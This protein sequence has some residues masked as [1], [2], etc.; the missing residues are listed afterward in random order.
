MPTVRKRLSGGVPA[1]R[2]LHCRQSTQCIDPYDGKNH[3]QDD[4]ENLPETVDPGTNAS[5]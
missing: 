2:K 3:G 4:H 1:G 5:Q